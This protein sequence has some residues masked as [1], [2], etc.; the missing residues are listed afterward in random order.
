M[1]EFETPAG[2]MYAWDDNVGLFIP[3]SPVMKA[4]LNEM[5]DYRSLSREIVVERLKEEFNE[6]EIAFC[7]DWI[8]KWEKIEPQSLKSQTIPGF[9][10]SDIRTHLLKQ[11]LTQLTLSVTEDCN[12]RCKYCVYSG[13]YQYTRSHSNKYMDFTVA[14]KAIDY[15]FSLLNEGKRYNPLRKPAIGFYGGE[16]LLNFKLI[17]KCVEYLESTY[18][19]YEVLYSMTTNGSLLDKEKANWL[20]KHDFSIFISLDGPEEEHNRHRV[21]RNGKGTFKDVMKN[22]SSIMAGKYENVRALPVFDWRTDLFKLEKFFSGKDIPP[23][24]VVSMVNNIDW[25]TY[26]EQFTREDRIAFLEQLKKARNCYFESL[27]CQRNSEKRSFFELLVGLDCVRDLLGSISIVSQDPLM[28]I[29]GACVPG[30]KIFVDV[31]GNFHV[32]ERINDKYPIGNVNKGLN[33][34]RIKELISTYINHM[35]KCPD[36]EVSRNCRQCFPR[37]MADNGFLSSSKVCKNVES[38]MKDSF[39]ETFEIAEINPDFV[40]AKSKYKNVRKHY[41]D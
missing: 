4:I 15:Y 8:A 40:E 29:T 21:Y 1:L 36:C 37:F 12:F 34:E 24:A 41:G 20:T 23:L 26:Y 14:K 22:I 17:K 3:I 6:E 39:V 33:F 25:G 13:F 9:H 31:G 19:N 38:K 5:S 30:T 27:S 10:E 32:C 28:P 16:P 7:I 35:D 18:A 11:G 2:N